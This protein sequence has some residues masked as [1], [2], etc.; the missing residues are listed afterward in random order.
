MD[1]QQLINGNIILPEKNIYLEV[2]A[3]TAQVTDF[4]WFLNTFQNQ[5]LTV[6]NKNPFNTQKISG[7]TLENFLLDETI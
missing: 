3:G 4:I 6:I 2:K 1:N 7:I 5:K